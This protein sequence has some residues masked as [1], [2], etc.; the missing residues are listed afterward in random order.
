MTRAS[1]SGVIIFFIKSSNKELKDKS[2]FIAIFDIFISLIISS[3]I[4]SLEI[5]FKFELLSVFL[6]N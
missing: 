1:K 6:D 3:S 5:S 4:S 2:L